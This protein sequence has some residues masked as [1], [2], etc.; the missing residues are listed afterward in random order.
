MTPLSLSLSLPLSV[1]LSC[2]FLSLTHINTVHSH[3]IN[4]THQTSSSVSPDGR[5]KAAAASTG[6]VTWG[7]QL[8]YPRK[9]MSVPMWKDQGCFKPPYQLQQICQTVTAY[10][11]TDK[12]CLC[13]WGLVSLLICYE[14]LL[15]FQ[16]IIGH[17][18][19]HDDG[20][21]TTP[22]LTIRSLNI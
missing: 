7:I 19:E 6:T 4:V 18:E 22:H 2:F 8:H 11:S 1:S 17:L 14:D 9:F 10:W 12:G 20:S 5:R 21:A 3:A 16:S 15:V 13:G